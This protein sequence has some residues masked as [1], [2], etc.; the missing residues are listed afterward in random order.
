VFLNEFVPIQILGQFL[1][2]EMVAKMHFSVEN[3][4]V[5]IVACAEFNLWHYEVVSFSSH[6]N[7]DCSAARFENVFFHSV[8]LESFEGSREPLT[9]GLVELRQVFSCEFTVCFCLFADVVKC[10]DL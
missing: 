10:V 5:E 7:P 1:C 8:F 4:E 2:D 3:P 6:Y 9:K